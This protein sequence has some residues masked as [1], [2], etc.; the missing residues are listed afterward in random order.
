MSTFY[1]CVRGMSKSDATR[2]GSY[3]SHIAASVQSYDGSITVEMFNPSNDPMLDADEDELWIQ[4]YHRDPEDHIGEKMK[5]S[6]MYGRT[7]FRGPLEKFVKAC[8]DGMGIRR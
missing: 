3:A 2:R 5:G 1:G 7:V 8:K 6:G 4:V